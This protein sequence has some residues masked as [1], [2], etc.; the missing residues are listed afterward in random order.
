VQYTAA[1]IVNDLAS[2]AHPASVYSIPT[3]ANAE[4]HVSMGANEARHVLA[5]V[6]DLGKVLALELMTA[7]QALDLRRDMINA[8]RDLADRADAAALAAKVQGGPLPGAPGYDEFLA[9]VE[10]LRAE[11]SAAEPFHPGEAVAAAHAAIREAVPFLAR[12]RALDVDLAAMLAL[13]RNG[14]VYAAAHPDG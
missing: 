5:M 4:D 10:A 12:D 14:G 13:M 6:E 8:A 1:A 2:R 3:S 11:L 9:E 7:A